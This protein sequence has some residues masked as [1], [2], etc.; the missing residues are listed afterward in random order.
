[1]SDCTAAHRVQAGRAG[2][3]DTFA[4]GRKSPFMKA[5]CGKTDRG[6]AVPPAAKMRAEV[7]GLLLSAVL[8]A[9]PASAYDPYDPANCNGGVE[10]DDK[11]ALVVSKVTAKPRVNFLKSPYDDDCK[12]ENCPAATKD[13]RKKSYLVTDDLVLTGPARVSFNG[14]S[15]TTPTSNRPHVA[16]GGRT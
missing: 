2:L 4:S 3:T 6:P 15:Y 7:F 12:A 1:M 16:S 5:G 8:L 14:V 10:W 11:R 9:G 13:C